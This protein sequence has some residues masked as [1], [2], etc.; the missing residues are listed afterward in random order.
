MTIVVFTDAGGIPW[1]VWKA[2][3][4]LVFHAKTGAR[5]ILPLTD[6]DVPALEELQQEPEALEELC[7]EAEEDK[8]A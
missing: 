5:R 8:A 2:S 3:S 6:R 7:R 1:K 4:R